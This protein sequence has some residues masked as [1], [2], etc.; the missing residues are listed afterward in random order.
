MRYKRR[1]DI[2]RAIKHKI[3]LKDKLLELLID[4]AEY[5]HRMHG[6]TF[7]SVEVKNEVSRYCNLIIEKER[8]KIVETI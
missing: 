4:V 7:I 6:K 1:V 8:Q 2:D 5:S 3:K